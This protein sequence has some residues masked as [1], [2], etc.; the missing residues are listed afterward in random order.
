M[1]GQR[2]TTCLLAM[3]FAL[4]VTT[5]LATAAEP[6]TILISTAASMTELIQALG[7][8]FSKKNPGITTTYNFGASGDLLAQIIQG[9]PVDIFISASRKHMDQAQGKGVV[10]P[11]SRK[12]FAGNVL[13]LAQPA[14]SKLVL[15]GLADLKKAEVERIGIGKPESVPAGQYAKDALV[16]AGVWTAVEGKLIYGSSVR[17]VLDYLRRGEIDC[18]LIYATDA[19]AATE[20]VRIVTEVQGSKVLYPAGLVKASHDQEAATMFLDYLATD[21]ARAIIQ[22][23]GFSLP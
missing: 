1:K 8:D 16:A 18:G 3:A 7:E 17:Q 20:Q 19:A 10:D 13:V 21:G 6:R 4:F 23:H 11:A 12:I 14:G 9:A 2:I 5:Q 22:Q 15:A